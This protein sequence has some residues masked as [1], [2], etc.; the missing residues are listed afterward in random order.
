MDTA[1]NSFK[2]F[3]A[4]VN[5]LHK[6]FGADLH[7]AEIDEPCIVESFD[8]ITAIDRFKNNE[9]TKESLLSWVN[10]LWFTDLYEYCENNAESISSVMSLLETLDEDGVVFSENQ[11]IGMI[12]ALKNN[13]QYIL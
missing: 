9:I 6:R 11:Y 12:E 3:Q 10:I 13:K 8:V 1:L 7:N 2:N 4:D 5:E